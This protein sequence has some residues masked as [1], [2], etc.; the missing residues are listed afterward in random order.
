MKINT[1]RH[2]I[3]I[4]FFAA[5]VLLPSCS[6][7]QRLKKADKKYA[8]GEYYTAAEMYKKIL[9]HIK[10]DDKALKASTAFKQAECY[11]YIN[12]P[13]A[14]SAYATAIRQKYQAQDSIVF[15]RQAQ[16]LQ[17]MGKYSEAEKSY[18][19]YLESHPDNYEA[20]A[21]AEACR[22][23]GEWKKHPTR[24]VIAVEKDFLAKR[25]SS[26]S[27]C[28]IDEEGNSVMFTSNR[29]A[30]KKKD[31]KNSPVT[32]VP[33]NQLYTTRKDAQGKWVEIELAEGLYE[34]ANGETG[35]GGSDDSASDRGGEGAAAGDGGGGDNKKAGTAEIGVCCFTADGRT[36]Y[37]TY[38]KPVNGQD[39]GAKIYTSSRAS[40]TW[41][42]PQEVKLFN[43]SSVTVGHPTLNHTGDTLW[44]AS[45]APGGYGGK[46]IWFAVQDGDHWSMPEN[47]GPE[48][49]S[50]GDEL[51]P[52]IRRNGTLYFSSNGHAG[53]G[54]LDLFS[55]CPDTT[56]HD[57]T[58]ITHYRVTNLG[59]PF[60]SN[61]DD[62]G[63]TFE[64]RTDNGLFS[65]NRNDKKGN[66]VIYR[67]TL[68]EMIFLVEGT[69]TDN[70]GT[71][72]SDVR[73]RLV[74]DDGT[75]TKMQVRRDG[76]YRIKLNKDVRY[77]MLASARGY[78]NHKEAIE[79]TG[80]ND[81]YT[82]TRNFTLSPISKPVTMENVFYEFGK[83][84]L[85][86]ESTHA[87]DG[88]VKL[89]QDNPN[90]T[91]ELSAHTD[92]VGN[93]AANKTLSE[94][95]AQSVVNYLIDKGI[96][97]DRL[98]PV[99]YGKERPVIADKAL[100]KEYSFIPVEQVLDEEFILS[101]PKEQQEI[102]NQINRRTEFKVLKTTYGLY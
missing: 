3:S 76:S 55:A 72:L 64:G 24:Y 28:Y 87:L 53:Y 73:L 90:I 31:K 61:G 13:K 48:I 36:M 97:A 86:P 49:N 1:I 98:T 78:L 37:F 84:D 11:R 34:V 2:Y 95:R 83:W 67:F 38:S 29:T 39:L 20:Q 69:V 51:F 30:R 82:A 60:N 26:F 5:M 41:G 88:L 100:N 15:L 23:V 22:N 93:A 66:D 81:S 71:P 62:F 16:V 102:C 14:A 58:G 40:G 33:V 99:G 19:L 96:A 70:T 12:H 68:P 89:L 92:L 8:I 46:D 45:D 9:P 57:S 44:F 43:D 18:N 85:T 56:V 25:A 17:Y 35:G 7:Q 42:E 52:T 74:G 77:V 75:N 63:I 54:G 79:T 21:G 6:V 94:K 101:L 50:T 47:A 10:K 65:S 80:L 59:V 32:G 4:V 91:I 27:P